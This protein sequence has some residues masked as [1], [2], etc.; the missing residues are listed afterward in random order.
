MRKPWVLAMVLLLAAAM[1]GLTGCAST[2]KGDPAAFEQTVRAIWVDYSKYI[3][4]GDAE[5]WI[6]LWDAGGVQLPPG[7]PMKM[8]VA[9]IKSS[10]AAGLSAVKYTTFVINISGTF[11]DHDYGFAYGNY[12]YVFAPSGGGD[13][14]VGDGKYETIFKRQA[15]GT[16]KI[17]RDC[18]NSNLP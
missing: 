10:I 18:F 2:P 5:N 12:K 15:D 11:V 8:S 17:F 13:Q 6:K 7:S 16:W 14:V 1:L 3:L 9:E 4:A